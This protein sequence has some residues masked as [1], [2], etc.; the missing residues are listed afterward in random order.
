MNQNLFGKIH[1]NPYGFA[2][3]AIAYAVGIVLHPVATGLAVSAIIYPD[4]FIVVIFIQVS[5]ASLVRRN[6][7]QI[8]N[9]ALIKDVV[10]GPQRGSLG[11]LFVL[12]DW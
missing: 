12:A 8:F 1:G 10:T 9:L 6:L 3:P 2:Y 7:P 5:A 11:K 4:Y